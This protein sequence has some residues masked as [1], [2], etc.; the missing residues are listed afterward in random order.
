[1]TDS[2]V[3]PAAPPEQPGKNRAL[4]KAVGDIVRSMGIVG[5]IIAV[6]LL[7]TWRPQPD[8]VREIDAAPVAAVAAA[9]ADFSVL[10]PRTPAGWRA[11][12]ARFEPTR[13]SGDDPVWF[14]GWVTPEQQ[15]A[16]VIQSRAG[17]ARFIAEQTIDGVPAGDAPASPGTAV[18]G[19]QP[20]LSAD[21]TQRSYVLVE[22]DLT[23]VVTG[24]IGWEDL[25][26]FAAMLEPVEPPGAAPVGQAA[27]G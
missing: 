5:G 17:N 9:R 6:V 10:Y 25:A 1:M 20:Y 8:P 15:Y 22:D 12:T 14:N 19:W 2:T 21:G 26:A 3:A 27:D 13:E 16:A 18:G 24:T 11:T 7:V 23:T 4:P